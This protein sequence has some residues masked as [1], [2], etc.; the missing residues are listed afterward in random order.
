MHNARQ[1]EMISA[2]K[3]RNGP[4]L[5]NMWECVNMRECSQNKRLLWFDHPQ[6]MHE[7]SW[8]GKYCRFEVDDGL[9]R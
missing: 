6:R 2:V 4:T 1:E 3:L 7:N 5:N 8:R 9:T